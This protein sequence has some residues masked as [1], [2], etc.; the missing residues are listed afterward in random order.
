MLKQKSGSVGNITASLADHRIAVINPS[1]PVTAKGGLNSVPRQLAMEY[2]KQG[3]RFNA[4]APAVVGTPLH[5]DGTKDSLKTLQPLASM[6]GEGDIV[7][8]ALYLDEVRQETGEVLIVNGGAR[9][10]RW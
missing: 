8:A 3:T 10:G 2:A 5:R 9:L 4:V 6:P 1:V 7:G